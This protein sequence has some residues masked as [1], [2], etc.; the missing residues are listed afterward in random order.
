[1]VS[2]NQELSALIT[3]FQAK[4]GETFCQRLWDEGAPLLAW[5]RAHPEATDA[6]MTQALFD[7]LPLKLR[8]EALTH[9]RAYQPRES[10]SDR[11]THRP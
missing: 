6:E 3:F 1:M 10:S 9:L 4:Y 2:P 11:H 8:Q 5:L 7:R